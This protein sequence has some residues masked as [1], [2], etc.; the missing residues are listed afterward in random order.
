M[1]DSFSSAVHIAEDDQLRSNYARDLIQNSHCLAPLPSASSRPI[2]RRIVQY[3]DASNDIPEDVRECLESW[4]PLAKIGFQREVFDDR[5]AKQFISTE[6]GS[7]Y[8]EA[9]DLCYHPAMRCDYFRLS[10]ILAKGGFYVDADEVYQGINVDYLFSDNNL[11]IQPLCYDMKSGAMVTPE[12][13]VSKHGHSREWIFY[14]NNNPIISPPGHAVIQF[15]L[16]R[17]TR[18]LLSSTEKPE[19]QSTTGPGN[20][21]ASLVMH[22]VSQAAANEPLDFFILHNWQAISISRWPLSYRDDQRN[23]RLA[24]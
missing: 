1:K 16:Q 22:A 12:V 23:W 8:T 20:F 5:A 13:F 7:L 17:A 14:F 21:T 4:T 9:F 18:I 24:T 15:A 6:L 11:K 19:I 2:P 10:Y 3:W